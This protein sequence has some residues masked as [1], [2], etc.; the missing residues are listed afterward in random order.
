MSFRARLTVIAALAIAVTVAAGSTAVWFV[1]RNQLYAQLDR[2]LLSQG[3]YTPASV[4]I[5]PDGAETGYL[6]GEIPL[7]ARIRSLVGTDGATFFTNTTFER[8]PVRELVQSRGGAVL[9]TIQGLGPTHHALARIK[10]W[11]LL[12]GGLGIALAAAL[13]AFV[14]TEALRPIRRL[15]AAAETV[16]ATGNLG[17][18]VVVEGTDELGRLATRFNAMLAAL[19]ESVGRQRRLVADASHELRTPLTAARANVDLVREG[20][21]PPVEVR[22]ALD[23]ASA[24]LDSLT[25]L[26]SDLV[27]LARGEERQL[28]VEEVQLEELV[29]DA[30]ERA[31]ARAPHATFVTSLS[32]VQVR[33]DPVLVERAVGNLL[34]NAVK[35]SPPGAPIEVTVRDGEVVVADHGPGIAAEDLPRIFDRFYRAA[36]ARAKPGAGLGLAI[37]REAAEAHGGSAI[38]ES[39][40]AGARFRLTLPAV[41]AGV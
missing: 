13:A 9:I 30:V 2:S 17:E 24:E 1:A 6:A 25:S 20:K 23:E 14:A 22:H 27:E 32:P 7:T 4:V 26:V 40:A 28:R 16:A 19:E 21:L 33:V 31:R 5:H 11:I 29:S 34:D 12:I 15:T 38:A 3:P 18:R 36:S 37:V 41:T 8:T 39:T 10:R 35:Y